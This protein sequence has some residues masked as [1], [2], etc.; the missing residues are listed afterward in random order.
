MQLLISRTEDARGEKGALRTRRQRKAFPRSEEVAGRK[1]AGILIWGKR[2]KSHQ[3][4][5]SWGS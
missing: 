5:L 4:L 1:D 2:L 3:T